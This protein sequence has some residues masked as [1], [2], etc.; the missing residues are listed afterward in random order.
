MIPVGARAI[1]LAGSTTA[2]RGESESVLWNPAGIAGLDH[3]ELY[4]V[5]SDDFGTTGQIFGLVTPMGMGQV[6]IAYYD[7]AVGE[8]DARDALNNDI[9]VLDISNQVLILSAAVPVGP[10]VDVGISYKLVRFESACAGACS[11][12]G[13]SST[14]HVFDVGA[15]AP[16]PMLPGL[17]VGAVLRNLGSSV[18]LEE[19]SP[20]DPLPTRIRVGASY[21]LM[22]GLPAGPRALGGP[23]LRI[24][25]DAQQ[26]WSEFD[27]LQGS[28]AAELGLRGLLFVRG[29]YAWAGEARS[30]ATLGVG[31]RVDRLILDFGHIF[32]DF[33]GFD[34]G[35]PFQFRVG[36]EF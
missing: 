36:L 31:L 11:E 10:L 3:R 16:L 26:T 5:R 13:L 27:D 34:D 20:A 1:G 29:G 22:D 7:L 6:G 17:T 28:A 21:V 24:L 9:G 19:G 12:F 4:Y 32:D 14:S 30:G 35:T 23:S 25:A 15:V 2:L 18:A 8:I 33:A